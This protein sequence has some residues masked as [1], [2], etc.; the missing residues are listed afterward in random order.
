MDQ[1]LIRTILTVIKMMNNIQGGIIANG[2]VTNSNNNNRNRYDQTGVSIRK[3][4]LI[5]G[6]VG[7][8]LGVASSVLGSYIYDYL[9]H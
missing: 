4:Q 1:S 8:L 9:I 6:T 3:L 7:F 2:P 5:S